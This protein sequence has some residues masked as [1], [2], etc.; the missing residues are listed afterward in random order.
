[1][2]K[3]R[4]TPAWPGSRGNSARQRGRQQIK[5]IDAKI[6]ALEAD[7]KRIQEDADRKILEIEAE[8]DEAV[9][10]HEAR[11]D[12]KIAEIHATADRARAAI[13]GGLV[14]LGD[15]VAGEWY[16][17]IHCSNCRYP[18]PLYLDPT[19]GEVKYT[20]GG[21]FRVPCP[22]CGQEDE[23]PTAEVVSLEAAEAGSLPQQRDQE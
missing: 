10:G 18:I 8:R 14:E 19:K 12:A 15:V 22:E 5:E 13:S 9:Q 16:T 4:F 6:A 21:T 3:K 1:M 17:A 2:K 23:Y 11:R 7:N 20:G